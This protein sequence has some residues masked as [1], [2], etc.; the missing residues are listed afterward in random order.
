MS[1]NAL[2]DLKRVAASTSLEKL[3]A[4]HNELRVLPDLSR[5]HVLAELR[6]NDNALTAVPASLS[7]NIRC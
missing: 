1:H 5:C 6:L 4:S 3:S 2:D 7:L